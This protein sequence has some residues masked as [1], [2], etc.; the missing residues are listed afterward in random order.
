MVVATDPGECFAWGEAVKDGQCGQG[1][2]GAADSAVAGGFDPFA[3]VCPAG[4]LAQGVQGVLAVLVV[5]RK[6]Y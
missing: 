1:G 5:A 2:S 4:G 3:G 6:K